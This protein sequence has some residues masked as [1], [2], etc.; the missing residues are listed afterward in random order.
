M[1]P[2]VRPEPESE[3]RE[4]I[5]R[6]LATLKAA[7]AP[8]E[9]VDEYLATERV[10]PEQELARMPRTMS[11]NVRG[12][13]QSALQGATFNFGDEITAAG[14]AL[15]GENFGE[16]LA[17]ERQSLG[18]F[19]EVNPRAALGLELTGGLASAIPVARAA[20]AGA[21]GL[22][23]AG[24]VAASGAGGGAIAGAGAGEDTGERIALG[25]LGAGAG[26]LLGTAAQKFATS[27]A[28][29]FLAR[30]GRSFL[31]AITDQGQ[32][33][34]ATAMGQAPSASVPATMPFDA[35]EAAQ[36]AA[37]RALGVETAENIAPLRQRLSDITGAGMGQD[38]LA[39]NLGGD[40][41]ARALRAAANQPNSAAGQMVNERLARQGGALGEG[42]REDIRFVTGAGNEPGAI[43][44]DRMLQ[45]AQDAA[46]PFYEQAREL[47]DI[48]PE[49]QMRQR[50]SSLAEM[51]ESQG[52]TPQAAREAV[53][54]V[55]DATPFDAF[56]D[57][58]LGQRALARAKQ[59]P[60][61][62]G[63]PDTDMRVLDQVYKEVGGQAQEAA[64][65]GNRE[66]AMMIRQAGESFRDLLAERAPVYRQATAAY[67]GEMAPRTAFQEGL[68][69]G[70]AAPGEITLALR[71][72]DPVS[73]RA[74]QL[75][76]ATQMQEQ[77]MGRASNVD[78][79]EMSQF[80]DVARSL[81]GTP[82]QRERIIEMYGQ[83]TYDALLARLMP[84]MEA[85]AQNAAARG[86]STTTKQLLDA[87][88]F[89]DDAMLDA[90]GNLAQGG[91]R[92]MLSNIAQR[93][94]MGPLDRAYRLGVGKV[95]GETADLLTRRGTGEVTS[96]LD[97]LEQRVRDDAAR[98]AAI[99]PVAGVAARSTLSRIGAQ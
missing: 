98:R 22:A 62:A 63:L 95:A 83:D 26:A 47:G 49:R 14:R 27:R 66:Q 9:D 42:V 38:V 88:A 56:L 20:T 94:V 75:G 34:L 2:P 44:L 51:L 21:Q 39:Y 71:Q 78:L 89:G 6:N 13:L 60:Q 17:E 40:Q 77:A 23:L 81:V 16:A 92:G 55:P 85:A 11:E 48:F 76:F 3:R 87:L 28:G 74:R 37:A 15:T 31:E 58:P 1:T 45:Q 12:G 24:R 30:R 72:D 90:I 54:G 4:R 35:R 91:P 41:S 33:A 99:S 52:V 61:L 53:G 57:S 86:N 67:A 93:A 7:N 25:G 43:A 10:T 50:V 29:D 73:R 36:R 96:L 84:K 65:A 32:P 18:E 46:R 64:T 79:G 97:L 68:E 80:R 5:R 19:R 82:A 69:S 8:Q 59:Y 70:T